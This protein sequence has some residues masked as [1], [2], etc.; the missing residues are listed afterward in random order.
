MCGRALSAH[1]LAVV[2]LDIASASYELTVIQRKDVLR[3]KDL[4]KKAGGAIV[5]HGPKTPLKTALAA[6]APKA[7]GSAKI[8]KKKFGWL[9]RHNDLVQMPGVLRWTGEAPGQMLDS[10]KIAKTDTQKTSLVD[11]RVWPPKETL[12][13][14][15]RHSVVYDHAHASRIHHAVSYPL[16]DDEFLP[17][18]IGTLRIERT[19]QP[20]ADI[21]ERLPD[22]FDIKIA[23]W[24]GDLAVLFPD[25]P[26]VRGKTARR[27]LVWNGK[28]LAPAKGLPDAI[29]K[30]G[31]RSDPW[32]SF[33]RAGFARSG[34]GVDVLIWE[35]NGFTAKGETFVKTWELTPDLAPHRG[36]ASSTFTGRRARTPR[37]PC[38]VRQRRAKAWSARASISR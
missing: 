29:A 9:V 15:G 23:A 7:T 12:I 14:K 8:D 6:P 16:V 18:P 32:P 25:E 38:F 3:A 1:G 10:G 11:C 21:L 13:S 5:L 20:P 35:G 31:T 30:K 33:L 24:I 26:T 2:Q 36:T 37:T 4:A 17:R 19:K 34:A 28:T 27:P 22:G